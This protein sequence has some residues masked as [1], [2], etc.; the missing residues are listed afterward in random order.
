[1][2]KIAFFSLLCVASLFSLC[3]GDIVINSFVGTPDPVEAGQNIAYSLT[4]QNNGSM[5]ISNTTF[6]VEIKVEPAGT[7]F[8]TFD[9]ATE[10]IVCSGT[11]LICPISMGLD[12]SQIAVAE[13]VISAGTVSVGSTITT[14]VNVSA[15]NVNQTSTSNVRATTNTIAAPTGDIDLQVAIKQSSSP[16][17]SPGRAISGLANVINLGPSAATNVVCS[18]STPPSNAVTFVTAKPGNCSTI[19]GTGAYTCKIG[20]LERDSTSNITI[21]YNIPND[22]P[23]GTYNTSI[24]CY[25][26]Q[27]DTNP[28]NSAAFYSTNIGTGHDGSAANIIKP[29]YW[30]LF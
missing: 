28:L 22:F 6:N 17:I 27:E 1:M 14:T 20:V 24:E 8:V 13:F 23:H 11:P 18:L 21:L 7:S 26:N 2:A 29:F 19:P 30:F 9:I 5:D 25:A 3:L 16:D 15:E 4:F 12:A 10:S